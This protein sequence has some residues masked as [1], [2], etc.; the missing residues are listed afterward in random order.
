MHGS[1]TFVSRSD[2]RLPISQWPTSKSH[3]PSLQF[4][5]SHSWVSVCFFFVFLYNIYVNVYTRTH[6]HTHTQIF[7]HICAHTRKIYPKYTAMLPWSLTLCLSILSSTST[8]LRTLL[9]TVLR[10]YWFTTHSVISWETL[11][12]APTFLSEEKRRR[13]DSERFLWVRRRET[14]QQREKER[15]HN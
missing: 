11:F 5:F 8:V 10:I 14:G 12:S 7:S 15:N 4:I 3:P 6:T 2:S 13:S 1:D 9:L